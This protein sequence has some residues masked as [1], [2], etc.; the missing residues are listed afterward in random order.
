MKYYLL[1]A[2]LAVALVAAAPVADV[3]SEEFDLEHS[4]QEATTFIQA[5]K[6]RAKKTGKTKAQSEAECGEVIDDSISEIDEMCGSMQKEIDIAATGDK[7]CCSRGSSTVCKAQTQVTTSTNTIKK[8]HTEVKVAGRVKVVFPSVEFNDLKK[9]KCGRF[10]NIKSYISIEKNIRK[11][12]KKCAKYK[13]EKKAFM[14]SFQTAHNYAT[15]AKGKCFK[16]ASGRLRALIKTGRK[17][18]ESQKNKK[19]FTRAKHMRCVLDG[20]SLKKCKVG[21]PP[22]IKSRK[23]QKIKCPAVTSF[24]KGGTTVKLP[25]GKTGKAK[26]QKPT[27]KK[28]K[29]KK[30]TGKKSKP[31]KPTRKKSK[32]KKPTRKKSKP[33][34]RACKNREMKNKEYFAFDGKY[35]YRIKFDKN[36]KGKT[37]EQDHSHQ[38]KRKCNKRNFRRDVYVGKKGKIGS[39]WEGGTTARACKDSRGRTGRRRTRGKARRTLLKIKQVGGNREYATASEPS[40]CNYKLTVNVPKCRI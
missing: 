8:C 27:G 32:P 7:S 10:F 25:T 37:L 9:G 23:L 29:P 2:A 17:I 39:W 38:N 36:G 3:A 15:T 6:T 31:K 30:P 16:S 22:S 14:K 33:K 1:A 13:G 4:F 19:A 26:P 11:L 24:C 35:C 34:K 12:K 20:I 5:L 40:T 28:S 21:S 18:C